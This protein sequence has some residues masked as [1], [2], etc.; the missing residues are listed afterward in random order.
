MFIEQW[1]R[2]DNMGRPY[3]ALGYRYRA[4]AP[5]AMAIPP[6]VGRQLPT[7]LGTELPLN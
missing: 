1:R 5:E 2:H 4:P 3:G 7:N 6:L